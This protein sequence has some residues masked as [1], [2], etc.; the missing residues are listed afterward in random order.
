MKKYIIFLCTSNITIIL[1]LRT[2][3]DRKLKIGERKI[4][5][6]FLN[7]MFIHFEKF[8]RDRPPFFSSTLTYVIVRPSVR[9]GVFL[10]E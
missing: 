10:S 5:R 6:H 1:Y 7:G 3:F 9:L 4:S 2:P 8:Y